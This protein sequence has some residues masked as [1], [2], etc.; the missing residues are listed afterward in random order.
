MPVPGLYMSMYIN[1]MG[2]KYHS[3]LLILEGSTLF[4]LDITNGREKE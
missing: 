4:F 3:T 2:R 1:I